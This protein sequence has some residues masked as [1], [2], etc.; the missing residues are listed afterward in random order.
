MRQTGAKSYSRRSFS[1]STGAVVST[2]AKQPQRGHIMVDTL[3]TKARDLLRPQLEKHTRT[4]HEACRELLY[5][6]KVP[7]WKKTELAEAAVGRYVA[8]L[9]KIVSDSLETVI[10]A[11]DALLTENEIVQTFRDLV[12]DIG[13][14]RTFV[15]Q[16]LNGF[17]IPGTPGVGIEIDNGYRLEIEQQS[18]RLKLLAR[19]PMGTWSRSE[20]ESNRTREI[21]MSA[22][23]PFED[24]GEPM[25]KK[26]D[27]F[28]A[29][30]FEDKMP[31]VAP[32]ADALRSRA[33]KVWYD[34]FTLQVG[35]SI[36]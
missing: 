23:R 19:Q 13:H 32:L 2:K 8:T 9:I 12:P 35:D 6:I 27:V 18:A 29:H 14:T 31:F 24:F 30:A 3:K 28:I 4:L 22:G 36:F 25:P 10:R 16:T 5:G 17:G 1:L 11:T 21:S 33:L 15:Y 20:P 34:D 26:F 7:E